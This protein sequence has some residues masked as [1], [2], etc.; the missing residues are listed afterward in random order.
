MASSPVSSRPCSFFSD[1]KLPRKGELEEIDRVPY[2]LFSTTRLFGLLCSQVFLYD[3]NCSEK[4]EDHEFVKSDLQRSLLFHLMPRRARQGTTYFIP[5]F[6][7]KKYF[8]GDT[9]H[10]HKREH[11]ACYHGLHVVA[12]AAVDLF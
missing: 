9:S 6:K 10:S 7:Q 5:S 2:R 4:A 11:L 8:L 1:A 12:R 3:W